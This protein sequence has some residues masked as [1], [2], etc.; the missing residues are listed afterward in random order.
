MCT[1][2]HAHVHVCWCTCVGLHAMCTCMHA[3]MCLYRNRKYQCFDKN[4]KIR[5]LN[6]KFSWQNNNACLATDFHS[7]VS[8]CI[9]RRLILQVLPAK[10]HKLGLWQRLTACVYI[11]YQYLSVSHLVLCV[12]NY[13][14]PSA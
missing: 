1:C 5:N 10:W 4:Q 14:P 8:A 2:M 9:L 12:Y 11:M 13:L 6:E 3:Y 7:R